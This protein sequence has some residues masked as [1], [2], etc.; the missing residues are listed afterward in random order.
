MLGPTP[1]EKE[2]GYSAT[3]SLHTE[4]KPASFSIQ[5][6]IQQGNSLAVTSLHSEDVKNIERTM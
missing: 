6:V 1:G 5:H 2:I 3:C 4:N